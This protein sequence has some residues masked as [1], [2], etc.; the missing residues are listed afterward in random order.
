ML[1]AYLGKATA[2]TRQRYPVLPVY[3]L[4]LVFTYRNVMGIC[5]NLEVRSTH[6]PHALRPLPMDFVFKVVC[7]ARFDGLVHSIERERERERE[8]ARE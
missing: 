5:N 7:K 1:L 2:A 3:A 4:F 8:R 6:V